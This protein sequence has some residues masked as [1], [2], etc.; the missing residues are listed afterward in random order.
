[1]PSFFRRGYVH[2]SG[3][4]TSIRRNTLLNNNNGDS[5]SLALPAEEGAA[6]S[7]AEEQLAISP[8]MP[9]SSVVD[10][11][12]HISEA[13]QPAQRRAR[14]EHFRTTCLTPPRDYRRRTDLFAIYRLLLPHLDRERGTYGLKEQ[15]LAKVLCRACGVDV[16]SKQGKALLAWRTGSTRSAAA[17]R[18]SLMAHD[19]ALRN[20]CNPHASGLTV[21]DV[22]KLLDELVSIERRAPGSAAGDK[23]QDASDDDDES[24]G[25]G[26]AISDRTKKIDQKANVLEKLCRS[27]TADQMK[28]VVQII[29]KAHHL[30]MGESAFLADLH[31]NAVEI[32]NHTCDLRVVCDKA[33]E[34]I[35]QRW[36]IDVHGAVEGVGLTEHPR[37]LGEFYVPQPSIDITVGQPLRSQKAKR[38]M[39]PA[40]AVKQIREAGARKSKKVMPRNNAGVGGGGE[41]FG[42]AASLSTQINALYGANSL[43][44]MDTMTQRQ[45]TASQL[46]I[47]QLLWGGSGLQPPLG[48]ASSGGVGRLAT[49]PLPNSF[50]I[51]TKFDGERVQLHKDGS[52]I[53]YYSRNNLEHGVA[54]YYNELNPAVMAQTTGHDRIVLDAELVI[55]NK[56]HKV[57]EPFGTIRST[58]LAAHTGAS[59]DTEMNYDSGELTAG[60]Y[61]TRE[62]P[63]VRD[64]EI[65]LMVFD[66]IY[67]AKHGGDVNRRPLSERLQILDQVVHDCGVEL[68][69]IRSKPGLPAD[70][71][72]DDRSGG[73]IRVGKNRRM[74]ARLMKLLPW[75]QNWVDGTAHS[76]YAQTKDEV[77]QRLQRAIQNGEE[78]IMIKSL[79][80]KWLPNDRSTA[81]LKLKPEYTQVMDIDA[82]VVGAYRGTGKRAKYVAAQYLLAIADSASGDPPTR[83]MSFCKVGTGMSDEDFKEL[84]EY[85]GRENLLADRENSGPPSNL[86]V[87]G[88]EKP[89]LWIT[90]ISRS[91]VMEV[92]ADI[93]MIRSNFYK[94]SYSLRFP[95][96]ERVR[97]PYR[98]GAK[99]VDEVETSTDLYERVMKGAEDMH[100]ATRVDIVA[101]TSKY[102][103]KR[104]RGGTTRQVPIA[105][106]GGIGSLDAAR[107]GGGPALFTGLKIHVYCASTPL[108]RSATEKHR[109]LVRLIRDRDGDVQ[110]NR[111]PGSR[112]EA[113][114]P[115]DG[116]KLTIRKLAESSDGWV[117]VAEKVGEGLRWRML[118]GGGGDELER[119]VVAASHLRRCVAAGRLVELEASELL[120]VSARTLRRFPKHLDVLGD[121]RCKRPLD[122]RCDPADAGHLD[123]LLHRAA[124]RERRL[125]ESPLNLLGDEDPDL[126]AAADLEQFPAFGSGEASTTTHI[127]KLSHD[128]MKCVR[129]VL[130]LA[131]CRIRVVTQ[132]D[133]ER[134]FVE[135]ALVTTAL[136]ELELAAREV[137]SEVEGALMRAVQL[138]VRQLG[139][140]VSF[141]G[142][143][144]THVLVACVSKPRQPS[145][146]WLRAARNIAGNTAAP[147]HVVTSSF[148]NGGSGS[149]DDEPDQHRQQPPTQTQQ[150]PQPT[151]NPPTPL[152]VRRNF[153]MAKERGLVRGV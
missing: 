76:L 35:A 34:L 43:F 89:D 140:S 99:P 75:Q 44:G 127:P 133:V 69:E 121:G 116:G 95:R 20:A 54:D 68:E 11:M 106:R 102:A 65:R 139:A 120:H 30:G 32:Y 62:V 25:G 94:A 50:V 16:K 55:W 128:G 21:A 57:F 136:G 137:E 61:D 67:S 29:L 153:L 38:V 98:E 27:L 22:N 58:F 8:L 12:N 114:G 151:A 72:L 42:H 148:V 103:A 59:W 93:R 36:R 86:S 109:A 123:R 81:W 2:G 48:A 91:V 28:W 4:T 147:V 78:G 39:D 71:E 115:Q 82:V 41:P 83:F 112:L 134:T 24:D 131:G 18:F 13:K 66:V 6:P 19:H 37:I 23:P 90:D 63:R 3:H 135:T 130:P 7:S 47:S 10:F 138:R 101:G 97:F 110:A 104:G 56:V 132:S 141:D 87:T 150:Q 125:S 53:Y 40:D 85:F 122:P 129:E 9:F 108:E 15:Q 26:G 73:S 79:S 96:V 143:D 126:N 60:V 107:D 124:K 105:F 77:Q 49:T 117:V 146:E 1:M 119:D 149:G 74:T 84:D 5:G 118:T 46:N 142:C 70:I 52:Q 14:L 51:E 17:G 100:L 152:N 111:P 144:A 31:P 88:Y 33:S 92:N 45:L 145:A 113:G 80:T 64:V